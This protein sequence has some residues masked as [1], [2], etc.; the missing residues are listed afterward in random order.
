M[1]TEPISKITNEKKDKALDSFSQ[2]CPIVFV[3]QLIASRN[4][5]LFQ[6]FNFLRLY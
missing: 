6:W 1:Q 3:V 2:Y 4:L 5:F